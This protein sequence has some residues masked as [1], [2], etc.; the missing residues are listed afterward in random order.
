M[1]TRDFTQKMVLVLI[2]L[3]LIGTASTQLMAMSSV[4][5]LFKSESTAVDAGVQAVLAGDHRSDEERARDMYRHPAETLAFFG[6]EPNMAVAEIWPGGGW[7]LRVIAPYLASGGGTYYAVTPWDPESENE[8]V[9][10]AIAKFDKRVSD[11]PDLYG[12]VTRTLMRREQNEFAAEGS[13]DAVLTFRNVH[14]WMTGDEATD[15]TDAYMSAFFKALKPGGVLGVVEHRASTDTDQ[16]PAAANGY[17]RQDYVI[18]LA[19]AAGFEFVEA[20]EINANAA[21]TADHPFGVWTLMP[22]RAS[23]RNGEEPAEDF[24][25]A[26]FDAIGESDRQTLKFRKPSE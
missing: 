11:N 9:Q 20:S 16:D 14:N 3:A 15:F 23:A 18:A 19:Q 21:D 5:S 4:R 6:I 12:N 8:R 25:R 7:Y 10:A 2:S 1:K 13:L 22:S 24:E 17:V 26:K